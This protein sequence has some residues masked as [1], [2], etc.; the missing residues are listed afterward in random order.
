MSHCTA[1]G[2][3]RRPGAK[4][5]TY[6]GQQLAAVP[7]PESL[8]QLVDGQAAAAHQAAWAAGPSTDELDHL[9]VAVADSTG[10]TA[11]S[12]TGAPDGNGPSAP[13]P[14]PTTV[15]TGPAG[16]SAADTHH[17][18]DPADTA[19]HTDPAHTAAHAGP[20]DVAA[21]PP[22]V[23]PYPDA[24]PAEDA[25][26]P[27][28]YPPVGSVPR[29]QYDAAAIGAAA[30][31]ARARVA[32]SVERI[33]LPQHQVG[34]AVR[35]GALVAA[36][37]WLACVLVLALFDLLNEGN[38][39][40]M[41]WFRGAVLLLAL[42]LRG[43]VG[44]KGDPSDLPSSW[45]PGVDLDGSADGTV[46]ASFMP[47]GV[48][49]LI[50]AAA[51]LLARRSDAW[52]GSTSMR[53]RGLRAVITGATCAAVVALLSLL[54][55]V[56]V[57]EVVVNARPL[58][59]FLGTLVLVSLATFLGLGAREA[60]VARL[61]RT[62]A[63]D[64]RTGS[65]FIIA[66]LSAAALVIVGAVVYLYATN[67]GGPVWDRPELRAL[68]DLDPAGVATGAL[69]VLVV[70][71]L[72]VP[73][74]LVVLGGLIIGASFTV[75]GS[76]LLSGGGLLAD[77]RSMSQSFGVLEGTAPGQVLA[78]ALVICVVIAVIVGLRSV[79]RQS[80]AARVW[81]PALV[82]AAAWLVLAWITG[83]RASGSARMDESSMHASAVMGLNA[84]GAAVAA[85]VWVSVGILV[86]RYLVGTLLTSAPRVLAF[87][88]GKRMDRV[89]QIVVA[90][91]LLRRGQQ[92]PSH[93]AGVA[94]GLRDGT[95][96][97]PSSPTT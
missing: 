66:C 32:G 37:S 22:P 34:R 83:Y 74:L 65:E 73:T 42:S 13:V 12:Q 60:A 35:D 61:P 15:V 55:E 72:F 29:P 23:A 41:Q 18:T 71:L 52:S 1:C 88:G 79:L 33:P 53:D 51:Y 78:A 9:E 16:G 76:G 87:I 97:P 27:P 2:R 43:S 8:D 25:P 89:W 81:Q 38:A 45:F 57:E 28:P 85:A 75:S 70:V 82:A 68:P 5:C 40:P 20:A 48:T 58:P 11:V 6:C 96:P 86:A 30:G 21:A 26:V 36:G 31:A 92:P 50:L 63:G 64:I 95:I 44:A 4:F 94:S 93:L 14:T 7:A 47:L 19:D 90:D 10:S 91:A 49:A 84:V 59:T 24:P 67:D 80:A 54:L 77:D 39:A 56:R 69:A 62:W 46:A 17:D 3:E